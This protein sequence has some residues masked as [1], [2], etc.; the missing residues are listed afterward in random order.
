MTKTKVQVAFGEYERR[1]IPRIRS[2]LYTYTVDYDDPRIGD[3]VEVIGLFE[4]PQLATV[5]VIGSNL[6]DKYCEP[7]H[8]F[9]RRMGVDNPMYRVV[10]GRSIGAC[11]ITED[12]PVFGD[13]DQ[14]LSLQLASVD[15]VSQDLRKAL[16]GKNVR[17]VV[18]NDPDLSNRALDL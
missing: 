7:I 4:N 12:G 15:P 8:R 9:V 14:Y 10:S 18:E 17:L 13:G 1:D 3:I 2:K 16:V 5:V 11:R 6:K